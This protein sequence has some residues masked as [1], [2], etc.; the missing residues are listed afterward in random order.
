MRVVTTP[1][2]CFRDTAVQLEHRGIVAA[3]QNLTPQCHS[4]TPVFTVQVALSQ[5]CSTFKCHILV[6][7]LVSKHIQITWRCK[8]SDSPHIE[9]ETAMGQKYGHRP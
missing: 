5:E 9:T 8:I 2:E 4:D 6:V 1:L 3:L 7:D